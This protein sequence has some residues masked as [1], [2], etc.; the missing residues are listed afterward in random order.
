[1][2][3]V[4]EL[5]AHAKSNPGRLQYGSSGIGSPHH[6]AGELFVAGRLHHQELAGSLAVEDYVGRENGDRITCHRGKAKDR[7]TYSEE[8]SLADKRKREALAFH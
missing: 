2:N 8:Q 4:P 3:S 6:L 7:K 5:I 1:M